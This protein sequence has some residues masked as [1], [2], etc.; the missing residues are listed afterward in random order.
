MLPALMVR[1]PA[2]PVLF[3]PRQFIDGKGF[4][5][6]NGFVSLSYQLCL[7]KDCRASAPTGRAPAP[8]C[9]RN[10]LHGAITWFISNTVPLALAP[11]YSVVP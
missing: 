1:S 11:P 9:H 10:P 2:P 6:Q 5:N 8:D 4:A 3:Y 7:G